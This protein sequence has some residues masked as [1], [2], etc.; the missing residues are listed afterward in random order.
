MIQFDIN[1]CCSS[2]HISASVHPNIVS[3]TDNVTEAATIMCIFLWLPGLKKRDLV[4]NFFL[5]LLWECIAFVS[6]NCKNK[7]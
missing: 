4:F 1:S 6:V 3:K 2:E 5:P 7:K